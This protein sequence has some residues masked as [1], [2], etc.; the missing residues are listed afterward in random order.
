MKTILIT[1]GTGFIAKVLFP[2]L[3]SGNFHVRTT[4][5]DRAGLSQLPK[6]VTG[7]VTGNL[8]SITDWKPLLE[9]VDVVVHLAA[10]VHQMNEK[11]SNRET[12]YDRMNVEVTRT[13]ANACSQAWV[14]R[15][16][17]LSS[18]K[19]MGEETKTGTAWN[20]SSPCNPQDAY[21]R[22]K[23][24]A[25]RVLNEIGRKTG[26]AV[27]ILRTPLVYGP[28]VKANMA[29]L[30]K[31]V[32]QKWPMPL[33]SV[34]NAR[35]LV[36]ILNLVDAIRVAL[37]HPKAAGQTYLVSDGEDVSTPELIRRIAV[38]IGKPARLF[39][40][41]L[42]L[43]RL[44]GRLTGKLET[45][46]RLIGSLTVDTAKIQ[47]ELDWKPPYTMEQG[48]RETAEWFRKRNRL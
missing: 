36:Y 26:I 27:V 9:D 40:V 29:R 48:L 18:I 41:P 30:F 19:A 4:L 8:E 28:G 2:I 23:H 45:I 31:I 15:F 44:A 11:A 20:E 7:F 32:D 17:F 14:K 5:R 25:E 10:R 6:G 43:L 16:I 21:G 22:S 47:N 1:G 42:S 46:D 39:S 24:N 35:S 3:T 34:E 38:A 33:Q 12:A 13:L 37:E